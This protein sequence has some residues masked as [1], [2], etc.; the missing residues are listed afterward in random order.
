MTTGQDRASMPPHGAPNLSAAD[1][2][3]LPS[4]PEVTLQ[5]EIARGGMGVVYR[6]R[7]DFLD[8]DVAVKLLAPH[9]QGDQF[10]AR[11]RREAKI[12]AGI[13]HP[14]IVG[15]HLAGTTT[16][17]QSYL[18]MEFVDGPSLANWIAAHGPVAVPSSL[19]LVRQLAA[20][21]G[22]AWDLGVIH[23]DVKAENILLE[24]PTA[25]AT[26][27]DAAFPFQPKL[28]DL[29]LARMAT[30]STDPAVTA[31][32]AV[33][34]TPATMAPEQFDDPDSVDYRA[35][36]YGLG[37]V[38]YQM[39]T[40]V[41][42]FASTRLTDIV[43]SKRQPNGPDPC[44][45]APGIPPAVG[46]LVAAML[47][48]APAD[49]P[50]SYREL[51]A[52]LDQLAA[53][54]VTVL[55]PVAR[56][57]ASGGERDQPNLLQT[58][59][60]AFLAA[61]GGIA[62]RSTAAFA[63]PSAFQSSPAIATAARPAVPSRRR[64]SRLLAGAVVTGLGAFA[65]WFGWQR[66]AR[67]APVPAGAP[68][69]AVVAV[70]APAAEIA[71]VQPQLAILGLDGEVRPNA[72]IELRAELDV[73]SGEALQYRW[74]VQPELGSSL[75]TPVAAATVLRLEGLPGDAFAIALEVQRTGGAPIRAERKLVL[76]YAPQDL[77]ADFLGRDSAWLA[78]MRP[79]GE[80]RRRSDDG[81]VVCLAD[82]FPCLC[83]RN[84]D[85]AVWRIEGQLLPE[86]RDARG[87]AQAAVCLRLGAFGQLALVCERQGAAGEQWS[88]S[89]QE[90]ERDVGRAGFTFRAL[91]QPKLVGVVDETGKLTGGS[92][93]V[94]RR[95]N[96]VVFA[97]GFP[98]VGEMVEHRERLRPSTDSVLLSL[99][100]RGGRAVFPMLRLW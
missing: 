81:A 88:M 68:D 65:A 100:A 6:G 85:G 62:A 19:R 29:G 58:A 30:A 13:R 48:A 66:S 95:G 61:G 89:L 7:Q 74:G 43:V 11:F 37:C 69:D 57:P 84:V 16:A 49:R 98:G 36:I 60:F 20:A 28:V 24:A 22:H 78:R 83:S 12:L 72:A 54:P 8:R 71:P 92:Y 10:A 25:T 18:V 40:G 21:L 3:P 5:H 31:P 75:A 50:A 82:E 41:A 42:A 93:S 47:A 97:F 9:L 34:G 86:R 39:L 33:M 14:N 79:R 77:F 53:T 64:G 38:L 90:V 63:E 80:W 94:T 56:Q 59:E 73:R 87:F 99:F 52:R 44:A 96:E 4:I 2:M 55:P 45:R 32:G 1:A 51:I 46:Q 27:I 91:R 67:P 23:R 15:C 76:D 70:P 26:A 17:G 35:D